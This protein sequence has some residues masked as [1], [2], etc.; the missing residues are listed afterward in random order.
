M[1]RPDNGFSLIEM[2]VGIAI[3][4]ILLGL[5]VP[6]FSEFIT[7]TRLSSQA[8]DF[9]SD[10]ALARGEAARRNQRVSVCAST[11]GA[12]CSLGAAN[13]NT[14]WIIFSDPNDNGNVDAGSDEEII[15]VVAAL[16][17]GSNLAPSGLVQSGRLQ[18]SPSGGLRPMSNGAFL[19]CKQ[20]KAGN[21]GRQI[22][23]TTTG[24]V[25][26]TANQG[27]S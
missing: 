20:G 15:K 16:A 9:M 17:G 4:A 24:A 22:S 25:R 7:N 10:L 11:D 23:I 6:S 26:I 27:C 13:W 2:M 18:F 14:G 8:N 3:L 5:A 12:S 1:S 21:Y 19:L